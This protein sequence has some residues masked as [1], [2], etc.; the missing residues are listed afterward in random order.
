MANQRTAGSVPEGMLP[1]QEI[2]GPVPQGEGPHMGRRACFV[3][4]GRC[5]LHC[6]PCDSKQTWDTTRYDLAQTCP[7][8]T[9]QGVIEDAVRC[10]SGSA[11]TVLTGGEPLLW[12]QTSAWGQV[13]A[14]LPGEVHVETNATIVPNAVTT[15]R[16]A[17][18]SASPKLGTMGAADP[19]KRRLVPAALEAF[20]D[21]ARD[22]RA[23][24]KF[25]AANI[26]EVDEAA[27]I[28]RDFHVPSDRV[29]IMPLGDATSW[30]PVGRDIV[31]HVMKAGFNL[32]GRLH[33]TLG[34]R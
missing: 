22:G 1:V 20:A 12:Q 3:R 15:Q 26:S 24:F 28:V 30:A 4:F 27:G 2:F 29:W 32:S 13:L 8:R 34:V 33:L 9:A 16:V 19:P 25:V 21:L 14:A 11:M 23:A 5:N 7:P 17:Y 6:P 18:F 10:G 31:G